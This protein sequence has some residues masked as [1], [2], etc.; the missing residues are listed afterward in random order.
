VHCSCALTVVVLLG[1]KYF[2]QRTDKKFLFR[3]GKQSTKVFG[4][5]KQVYGKE[6]YQEHMFW[7]GVNSHLKK[8]IR[9]S[10]TADLTV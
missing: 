1:D 10:L 9:L 4:M 3:L 6:V 5:L 2:D 7:N 8:G